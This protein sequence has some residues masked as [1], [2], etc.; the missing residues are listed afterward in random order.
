MTTTDGKANVPLGSLIES[1]LKVAREQNALKLERNKERVRRQYG[2]W[3]SDSDILQLLRAEE[4]N[5]KCAECQGLPCM[6]SRNQNF[7]Q[8]IQPNDEAEYLYIAS[9]PCK[10]I[11]A[12]WEQK[13]LQQLFKTSC[14]PAKYQDLTF[15]DYTVDA[16]NSYAVEVARALVERT[17]QGVYYYGSFGTGKTM[18]AAIIAQEHIKR[19]R[20][21]LFAKL[22]ELLRSIRATYS[23]NQE[24]SDVEILKKIYEVPILILDD[25]KGIPQ[26]K[27]AGETLF[28]IIDARLNA[29]LQTIMTSNNTLSELR[30]AFDNPIDGGKSYDGS[31]IYDRCKQM[32]Y[33]ALLGGTSRR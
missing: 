3:L 22:P 11:R 18:L 24:L 5:Q 25:V 29:Q 31:R 28:D 7:R 15:E 17:D 13:R 19:G 2:S 12:Q 14:I 33:P 21:V 26:K 30:E 23:P 16:K 9:A 1:K 8:V 4:E 27:F 6:K 10:Y 20:A 32:C